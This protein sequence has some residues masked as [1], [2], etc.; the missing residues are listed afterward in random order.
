MKRRMHRVLAEDGRILIV[1]MDHTLFM[2]EP[3]DALVRYG[4]TCATVRSAGADAFLAP[5]G[6]LVAHGDSMAGAAAIASVDTTMPY[7]ERAVDQAMLAGADAIKCMVYP[8]S[9]DDSVTRAQRLAADAA[10]VG[11]PMLAEPIPGG[12][13]RADMRSA[14]IIAAGARI[15]AELGADFVKTFYT[16]DPESMRRVVAYAGVPVVILG[17]AQ[18]GTLRALFQEVYDAVVVAGCAGAAI[19][20]NIWRAEDPAAVTRG[21]MAVIH[22]GASVDDAVAIAQEPIAA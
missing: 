6:S 19:G 15:C 3:V 14:E 13:S 20:N 4:E 17:G 16:G 12:F 5:I 18:K 8:F 21:L 9:D 11:L 2:T 7:L 1:A 22:G 10:R